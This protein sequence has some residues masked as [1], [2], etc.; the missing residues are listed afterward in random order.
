[1]NVPDF[2]SVQT[3]EELKSAF[4]K[5]DQKIIIKTCTDGYDGKGSKNTRH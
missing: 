1:M 5:F 4:Y 2:C 3:L